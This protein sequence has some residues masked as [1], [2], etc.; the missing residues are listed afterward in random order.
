MN[1]ETSF[2]LKDTLAVDFDLLE[3]GVENDELAVIRKQAINAF[4]KT[5]FPTTKNEEWKFTNV[6]PIVQ[7]NYGKYSSALLHQKIDVSSYL[8]EDEKEN[9]IVFIN[10][11]FSEINSDFLTKGGV[12]VDSFA[13]ILANHPDK[14][15]AHFA[16]H[17][18]V[19]NYPFV[20]LNTALTQDGFYIETAKSTVLENP[21]VILHLTDTSEG[22]LLCHPRNLIVAGQ[23]S[24]VRVIQKFY[25]LDDKNVA[26][27]NSVT[28][29]IAGKDAK[30]DNYILQNENEKAVQINFTQVHQEKQSVVHNNTFTF[31]GGFTRNDL[32]FMLNDQHIESFLNGLYMTDG[33][34]LVDNHSL[35]DH[36][37]PNC[38]SDEMYKGI[39]GGNSKGVFNGK[40]MVR[41][42]AQ[43]TNA[44]QSNRNVLTSDN[45]RINTKPQLEI[46]ADDVRCTHGAT[47]GQLNEEAL[48][49][50]QARGIGKDTARKILLRGFAGEV[51]ERL[52]YEPIKEHLHELIEKKLG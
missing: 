5:G 29:I 3:K 47:T 13:N 30:V 6:Q 35:V 19:E 2:D 48:F 42:D 26:F 37:L 43:Q 49:Y 32:Q 44:F 39:M 52:Q 41:P 18:A 9:V 46:F 15:K 11:Q 23:N 7:Q 12:L 1:I 33:K 40:I 27:T 50:M 31:G 8:K 16:Q 20:A 10:G 14:I 45:A 25:S 24:E 38:M 28:E 21:F 51:V 22:N 4:N 34:Q 17:A 36:A